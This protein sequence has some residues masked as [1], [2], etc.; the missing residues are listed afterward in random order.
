MK[1]IAVVLS[2]C[3]FL[4][5]AEITESVSTLIHLSQL[6]ANYKIFAPNE[7][8]P[9]TNHADTNKATPQRNSLEE[10]A[11][12]SRGDIH[13]ITTLKESDFDAVIFPGGFGAALNLCT[14]AKEGAN[15]KVLLSVEKNSDGFPLCQQTHRCLVYCSSFSSKSAWPARSHSNHWQ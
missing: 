11:R 10:A 14:W 5:G 4:D 12:I 2:G 8:F 3:G 6:K 7:E 13:D 1:N 9:A 15:C